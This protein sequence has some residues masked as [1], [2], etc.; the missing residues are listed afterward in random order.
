MSSG[1][2]ASASG[3]SW[4]VPVRPAHPRCRSDASARPAGASPAS[5]CPASTGSAGWLGHGR[6][7]S[8]VTEDEEGLVFR[9]LFSFLTSV[10]YVRR[11][12]STKSYKV[13]RESSRREID[14]QSLSRSA[15]S[16]R[17]PWESR[18]IYM[19]TRRIVLRESLC[20]QERNCTSVLYT[21][22]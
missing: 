5:S 22:V 8:P 10:L 13:L 9:L 11:D 6:P 16:R 14:T 1:S 18:C 7:G 2:M 15:V 17:D 4:P 20:I 21:F 3:R 19:Y 12:C